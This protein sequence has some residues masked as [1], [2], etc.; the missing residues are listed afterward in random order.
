MQIKV[1]K[2]GIAFREIPVRYRRRI[3]ASKISGTVVGSLR[4]GTKIL[5]TIARLALSRY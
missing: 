2:H 1:A 4:A 5:A 3:G